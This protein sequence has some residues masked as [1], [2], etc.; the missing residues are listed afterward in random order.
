MAVF[1]LVNQIQNY[2]WG[3]K[4]AMADLLGYENEDDKPMAE[5]W[6]GAHP[7]SPSFLQQGDGTKMRLN[8]YLAENPE[9]ALGSETASFYKNRLPFLFKVLAAGSPLSIQAHPNLEQAAIGFAKENDAGTAMDAF[10]RNYK[11]DNHKPEII[12]ALSEYHAMRGFKSPA[13]IALNFRK[14]MI[15]E[16]EAAVTAME[17][18]AAIPAGGVS[19]SSSVES[20]VLKTFFTELMEL[21][22]SARGTLIENALAKPEGELPDSRWIKRFADLYPGDI[23]IVSPLYLNIVTLQPGEAMYL[24]A[25]ELHAYLEGIGMELMANSDNVLRGGLTPKHVDVPELVSTLRFEPCKP[26]VLSPVAISASESGYL[27]EAP[28]FYLSRIDLNGSYSIEEGG[29][30]P[31]LPSIFICLEG[32]IEITDQSSEKDNQ[33]TIGRGDTAF[34]SFGSRISLKGRGVLY[35]ASMPEKSQTRV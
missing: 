5:L 16:L 13:S 18:A 27:T 10:N 22:D 3:S 11:D 23:G 35:R 24:P 28:E 14:I 29:Y 7:K 12:C 17:S 4:S 1:K 9:E 15:P 26:E 19:D 30:G 25:G 2:A 21:S 8:D 20:A 31:V 33:V 6:M 34:A 32:N